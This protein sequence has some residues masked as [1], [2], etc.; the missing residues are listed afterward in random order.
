MSRIGK[1]PVKIPSGVSVTI[2]P[3]NVTVS[4]TKGT[5][6]QFM[7]PGIDV[8]QN[9]DMI[10]VSRQSEEDVYKAKHGLMRSLISNM[11]T[12]V[13]K[14]YTKQLEINGVGFK[15]AQSG[16]GLKFSLGYSH[17]IN[18]KFPGWHHRFNRRQ[19]CYHQRYQQ[20]ASR[21]SRS[22]NQSFAQA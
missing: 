17:D 14:G 20:T 12:G 6:K 15:V 10:V 19:Y 3:E 18:F 1:Q 7:F 8:A 2:D 21:P 9:E 13:S 22:G 11:V 5:L 16:D 4:G